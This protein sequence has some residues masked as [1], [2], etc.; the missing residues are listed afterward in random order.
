MVSTATSKSYNICITDS[1]PVLYLDSDDSTDLDLDLEENKEDAAEKVPVCYREKI[2]QE[3]VDSPRGEKSKMTPAGLDTPKGLNQRRKS[4]TAVTPNLLK[5]TVNDRSVSPS[6][7]KVKRQ[8][9][10]AGACE[11]PSDNGRKSFQLSSTNVQIPS[12]LRYRRH[13][14]GADGDIDIKRPR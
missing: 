7:A 11:G 13:R 5:L 12:S 2:S 14:Y 1:N 8:G 4:Q 10:A 3:A 6:P 9:L